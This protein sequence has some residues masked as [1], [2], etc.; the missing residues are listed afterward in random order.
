MHFDPGTHHR[1]SIRL[2]GYDYSQSG[3]YVITICTH[4]KECLFG[5]VMEGKVVLSPIGQIA[6]EFWLD[7]PKRFGNVQLDES[8]VMPNH[9]H[10]I[11]VIADP[12]RGVKF[13][14]PTEVRNYY[15]QISPNRGT[16]PL[17]V[18]TYKSAVSTWCKR[19]GYENFQWQRNYYDH[20][21][22]DEEDLDQIREYIANNPMKWDLDS[23]N[24]ESGNL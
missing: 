3:G 22:R 15:S 13:N 2:K 9:V 11:I 17:T 20:I 16:I 14:A 18:R 5:D 23:E 1:K 19:N 10:G 7:I 21:V 4:N 24:P 6:F 12:C 8:I